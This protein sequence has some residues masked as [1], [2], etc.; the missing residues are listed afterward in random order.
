MLRSAGSLFRFRHPRVARSQR[1]RLARRHPT[2]ST[3]SLRRP[4]RRLACVE[5]LV[6]MA[7]RRPLTTPLRLKRQRRWGGEAAALVLATQ[8]FVA[9]GGGRPCVGATGVLHRQGG[10]AA[11][12]V[13]V[14]VAVGVPTPAVSLTDS[15]LPETAA[16]HQHRQSGRWRRH[17]SSSARSRREPGLTALCG[18]SLLPE[19]AL[20]G[21]LTAQRVFGSFGDPAVHR[22]A[23]LGVTRGR[24]TARRASGSRR[25]GS[26]AARSSRVRCRCFRGSLG[27]RWV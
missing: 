7:D 21:T 17:C 14:G 1:R 24:A 19:R 4:R 8:E 10:R 22:R 16:L 26:C 6:D 20:R 3:S 11:V 15:T 12:A 2:S 5:M 25:F 9:N 27:K 23:V 18:P 13:S